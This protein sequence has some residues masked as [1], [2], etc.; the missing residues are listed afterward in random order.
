MTGAG[1]ALV[2]TTL[3]WRRF[4]KSNG[5]LAQQSRRKFTVGDDADRLR[6]VIIIISGVKLGYHVKLI[7]HL[8][9]LVITKLFVADRANLHGMNLL[10]QLL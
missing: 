3:L 9:R 4:G 2:R 7:G 8:P 5:G 6:L 10:C 1:R